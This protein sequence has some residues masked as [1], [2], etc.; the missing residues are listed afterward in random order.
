MLD[1]ELVNVLGSKGGGGG[2]QGG[3]QEGGGIGGRGI[4]ISCGSSDRG[5][6]ICISC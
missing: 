6:V 4:L 2:G 5:P 3:G 1:R